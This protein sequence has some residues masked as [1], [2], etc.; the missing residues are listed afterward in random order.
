M[1]NE[2]IQQMT[3]TEKLVFFKDVAIGSVFENK[4]KPLQ[5]A[6]DEILWHCLDFMTVTAAQQF[7][8][9]LANYTLTGF[10]DQD[11]TLNGVSYLK[12]SATEWMNK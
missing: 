4:D 6:F 9:D 11:Q 3:Y 8:E 5:K 1:L 10:Y 7:I 12:K 2:Q